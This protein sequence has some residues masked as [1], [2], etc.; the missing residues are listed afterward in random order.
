M[1]QL[2][3]NTCGLRQLRQAGPLKKAHGHDTIKIDLLLDI[4]PAL[5]HRDTGLAAIKS[6]DSY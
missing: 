3:R 4:L 1:V 2:A 6:G 5:S